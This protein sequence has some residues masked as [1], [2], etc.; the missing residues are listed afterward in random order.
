MRE[1]DIIRIFEAK[2]EMLANNRLILFDKR[3]LPE[4]YKMLSGKT[5]QSTSL[6]VSKFFQKGMDDTRYEEINI[7]NKSLSGSKFS[8]RVLK[9]QRSE[10]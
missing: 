2:I 1:E 5:N 3:D 10:P 7:N 9:P 6:D 4:L 8:N